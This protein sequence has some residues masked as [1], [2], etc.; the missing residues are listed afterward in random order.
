M[1]I[2]HQE[3]NQ[4]GKIQFSIN[5]LSQNEMA[6]FQAV[7]KHFRATAYLLEDKEMKCV[8]KMQEAIDKELESVVKQRT[9]V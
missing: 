5:E 3:T 2:D 6:I 7:F 9:H 1:Y 8:K 4:H